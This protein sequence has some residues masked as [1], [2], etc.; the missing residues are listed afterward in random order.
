MHNRSAHRFK[1]SLFLQWL[2]MSFLFFHL[3]VLSAQ[4]DQTLKNAKDTTAVTHA[5][6]VPHSPRKA[7]LMSTLLPGLG[8]V[9][10]KKYWKV[11][12]IYAGVGALAY[13]FQFNQ[14]RYVKYRDAYKYRIDG[15]PG[16]VDN[17]VGIYSD[18]NL[19]TLYAYYHRYRDLTVIGAAAVYLLNILDATVD[20]HLYH[21]DVSDDLSLTITPVMLPVANTSFQQPGFSLSL[22][23]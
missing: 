4:N 14:S 10:N 9:Y 18:D 8:Q 3:N 17:Y 19:A 16:T 7:A 23:F 15:D 6:F 22:Q 5:A 2:G 11:P 20:A 13:S 21:F 1:K 12:V